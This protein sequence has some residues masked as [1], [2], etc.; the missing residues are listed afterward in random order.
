M[1]GQTSILIKG[2]YLIIVLVAIM[3]VANSI[4]QHN[5]LLAINMREFQ[6][7]K[8][9]LNIVDKM[10]GYEEGLA[11]LDSAAVQTR[12]LELGQN[13]IIDRDKLEKFSNEFSEYEPDSIRNFNFRYRIKVETRPIDLE[14]EEAVFGARI[15]CRQVC[16][17][18]YVLKCYWVCDIIINDTSKK[19]DVSIPSE[20]WTFGVNGFSKEKALTERMTIS[21]PVI[22]YYN[23]SKLMPAILSI[24][25]AD[26]ELEKIS[27]L[28]DKSCMSGEKVVSDISFS[29]PIY[30]KTS[31]EKNYL[32]MSIQ[33]EVC[34][35]LSCE[36]PII[37]EGT[38]T[39]GSYRIA[40]EPNQAIEV[41]I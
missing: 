40:I 17:Q 41:R 16:Y 27:N 21:I 9:A 15:G 34:Q 28:I 35:R 26:G 32:C 10:V 14:T 2:I 5:Y 4:V 31:G 6:F 33:Q 19:I 39:P 30:K 25:I 8:N 1:K 24:D 11:F 20:S 38:V 37:L 13:R 7:R 12:I 23:K 29:Y 18:S 36:K 22:V 3:I